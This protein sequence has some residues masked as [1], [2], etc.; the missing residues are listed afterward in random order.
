MLKKTILK[1]I[2]LSLL[3]ILF[4]LSLSTATT[5][6]AGFY[7]NAS[8][9][10]CD[11][12]WTNA[13]CWNDVNSD[14][15][16]ATPGSSDDVY[17]LENSG[18]CTIPDAST[19][20][21]LGIYGREGTNYYNGSLSASGSGT[22]TT[23]ELHLYSSASWGTTTLILSGSNSTSL[24]TGGSTF[25]N[26]QINKGS[27]NTVTST[28]GLS[29][30][31][32][33]TLSSGNLSTSGGNV[34]V[35]NN[36]TV[37]SGTNSISGGTVSV[38]NNLTVDGGTINLPE[39]TV[40]ISG[41]LINS[42]GTINMSGTLG[43]INV[44]GYAQV[45]TSGTFNGNSGGNMTIEGA[46]YYTSSNTF[47][48][49][50]GNLIV[51]GQVFTITG[52][53]FDANLGTIKLEHDETNTVSFSISDDTTF[54]NLELNLTGI[55]AE[56]SLSNS[57]IYTIN[58]DLTL[59]RGP[60]SSSSAV[61]DLK[62][63]LNIGSSYTVNKYATEVLIKT[64]GTRVVTSSISSSAS[65][66]KLEMDN[67]NNTLSISCSDSLGRKA[68]FVRDLNLKN[69]IINFAECPT[70]PTTWYNRSLE[71]TES[72]TMTG[73]QI[74][75]GADYCSTVEA[76]GQVSINGGSF[77]SQCSNNIINEEFDLFDGTFT[78]GSS[79]NLSTNST[80]TISGGTFTMGS[81]TMTSAAT[82]T[83]EGGVFNSG[84]GTINLNNSTGNSFAM[85]AG[86]FNG[87]SAT[88]NNSY[89]L[90]KTGGT[91][92]PQTSTFIFTGATYAV[93][94]APTAQNLEFYNFELNKTLDYHD[95]RVSSN[96]SITILNSL[97][98][99]KGLIEVSESSTFVLEG[100]TF[101]YNNTF[102]GGRNATSN[103]G[104]IQLNCYDNDKTYTIPSNLA[105]TN[106]PGFFINKNSKN[107]CK[108]EYL[109]NDPI[110]IQGGFKIYGTGT[111]SEGSPEFQ[112]TESQNITFKHTFDLES[113]TFKTNDATIVHQNSV[114]ISGGT[115]DAGNSNISLT[116]SSS[117]F[118]QTGGLFDIRAGNL[119]VSGA[120]SHTGGT[121][122]APSGNL[123][124]ASN[125]TFTA[126]SFNSNNGTVVLAGFNTSTL[127]LNGAT[128]ILNLD[129]LTVNRTTT[130][131]PWNIEANKTIRVNNVLDLVE[132]KI[133][134]SNANS[135]LE[136]NKTLNWRDTFDGGYTSQ[137]ATGG[138]LLIKT[139]SNVII[140]TI[141]SVT[142]RTLPPIS[143]DNSNKAD[144]KV[145]YNGT[146]NITLVIVDI[147]NTGG[148]GVLAS[149]ATFEN[150][151]TANL[152]FAASS[153]PSSLFAGE[154]NVGTG[155]TIALNHNL[156]LS[157]NAIF[158]L[159]DSS[160]TSS[161]AQ[162]YS[163]GVFEATNATLDFN[164][165][166]TLSGVNFKA[167]S[168]NMFVTN[169]FTI[170]TGTTFE[171]NNG[172]I[173]FDGD[174]FDGTVYT[175]EAAAVFNNIIINKDSARNFDTNGDDLTLDGSL[176]LTSGRLI[177][178]ASNTLSLKG[179]WSRSNTNTVFT[180][181][182]GTVVFDGTSQTISGNNTF[183][184]FTKPSNSELI[185]EAGSKT[186]IT[187][188]WEAKGTDEDNRL[189]L[190]SS[191]Q[192]TQWEIDPQGTRDIEFLDVQDSNNINSTAIE[193]RNTGSIAHITSPNNTNWLFDST[194][195]VSNL[196]PLNLT[197]GSS[198]GQTRPTFT[199]NIE[200]E[201]DD[202]IYYE[203]QVSKNSTYSNL[204]I[205]E[206]V[207]STGFVSKG[208]KEYTPDTSLDKADYW[209]R[210]RAGNEISGNVSAWI[211]ASSE[212]NIAFTISKNLGPVNQDGPRRTGSNRPT[213]R[214]F[215]LDNEDIIKYTIDF[216]AVTDTSYSN[217]IETIVIE[218]PFLIGPDNKMT[219]Q[220]TNA[221]TIGNYRWRI[222]AEDIEG[223]DGFSLI[224]DGTGEILP[225]GD[226][227]LE[228][229]H[230]IPEY[231]TYLYLAVFILGAWFI[232]N[233]RKE[234]QEF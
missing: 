176:T 201:N 76:N 220:L 217:I 196:G 121:F 71:F 164:D 209:W 212:E 16:E 179:D 229:I 200:E 137:G 230:I 110:T 223:E 146:E 40:T 103:Y 163:G 68:S 166:L 232:Y 173:T 216:T 38:G 128:T 233:R 215:A 197:N 140:P 8:N 153:G 20:N 60:F 11:G 80:S 154:L 144:L 161:S 199:F 62:G 55:N 122:E 135:I 111:N 181:G 160:L 106:I 178:G 47:T 105:G 228:I 42:S 129:N 82:L 31:N 193:A 25:Y 219:A 73:G 36:L 32:N 125:S 139:D 9:G 165:N 4:S 23:S 108:L 97:I 174:F 29:V 115:Y 162:T 78:I 96:S 152:T 88:I 33:L 112:S 1:S 188:T 43:A 168:S 49:P 17:F 130:N 72:L 221:L 186:T 46:F 21:V 224:V 28:N 99:T 225:G 66:P 234:S 141:S 172:T 63:E 202:N 207:P 191:I 175:N 101:T 74:N 114:S 14:P 64:T 44:A 158:N 231:N 56:L 131:Y 218:E 3:A 86:T 52:N 7:W 184:N 171:H 10:S 41:N 132:G 170:N 98:L 117:Q 204:A 19:I 30:S 13:Y 93:I 24:L 22:I 34:S 58:G 94:N 26:L 113:G 205:N 167:P 51:R 226:K 143:I 127:S 107:N 61:I 120:F 126:D 183:Y 150:T 133:S 50:G 118:A 155:K 149:G 213:L 84:S 109:G 156:V 211:T 35:G 18:N 124:L 192:G 12:T 104:A 119:S 142:G 92:N 185:F 148:S 100:E 95:I 169:N 57:R 145:S 37:S 90:T 147:I 48:A 81:G 134:F 227:E 222:Y 187:G 53:D 157:N 198:I 203:I 214:W 83:I 75:I 194:P 177:M 182:N 85:T 39:N 138:R 116:G 136:A 89:G 180:P 27:S 159:Q 189:M 70:G 206:R 6:A 77:E 65:V 208:N 79:A 151:G 5:F 123:T 91:F 69:G 45:A 15:W 195:V 87:G 102:S 67:P 2:K 54:N 190:K 59:L 210:V